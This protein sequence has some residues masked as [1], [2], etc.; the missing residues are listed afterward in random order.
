M[1]LIILLAIAL[2]YVY[3]TASD[4]GGGTGAE[5]A[6]GDCLL[7]TGAVS[8]LGN[9]QPTYIT[10]VI[11]QGQGTASPGEIFYR[12]A[13]KQPDGTLVEQGS[14]SQAFADNFR[15]SVIDGGAGGQITPC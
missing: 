15:L 12:W 2:F 14:F 10:E 13:L 11:I 4:V 1:A 7:W 8:A 6:V 5:F 9:A 3:R